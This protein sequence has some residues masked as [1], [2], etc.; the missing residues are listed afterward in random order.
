MYVLVCVCLLAGPT[1]TCRNRLVSKGC[2][3][4]RHADIP[5][6]PGEND[7][8]GHNFNLNIFIGISI[9]GNKFSIDVTSPLISYTRTSSM[10]FDFDLVLLSQRILAVAGN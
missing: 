9:D 10:V 2:G 1:F 3:I 4:D 7:Y 6:I 5:D 8:N